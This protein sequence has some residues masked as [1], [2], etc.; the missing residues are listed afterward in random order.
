MSPGD[1]KYSGQLVHGIRI[2]VTERTQLQTSR[3]TAGLLSA[4]HRAY[5]TELTIDSTRFD[6]LFGS[7]GARRVILGGADA[8]AVI[9]STYGPAY[10]FR[11]RVARYLLY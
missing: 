3:L 8:D 9:D 11:Q 7:P 5:P 2:E 4:I 10:A 6:R 1:G